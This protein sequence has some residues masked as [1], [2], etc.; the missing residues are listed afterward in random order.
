MGSVVGSTN[1]LHLFTKDRI[2]CAIAGHA[3]APPRPEWDSWPHSLVA[4]A[5]PTLHG[6]IIL[7]K[8]NH[9]FVRI[10][11]KCRIQAIDRHGEREIVSPIVS[12]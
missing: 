6:R 3:V 4:V 1:N 9:D 10:M 11:L 8:T 12:C 7:A 5:Q 2:D